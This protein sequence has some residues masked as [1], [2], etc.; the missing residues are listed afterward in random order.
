LLLQ[1]QQPKDGQAGG[2]YVFTAHGATVL[3]HANKAPAGIGRTV[4]IDFRGYGVRRSAATF[5][6]AA[7]VPREHNVYVVI[8]LM[9]EPAPRP[10]G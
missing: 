6:A 1:A 9:G 10:R 7:G 3:H 5:M 8:T 2:E 4:Q